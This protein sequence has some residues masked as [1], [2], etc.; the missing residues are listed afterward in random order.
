MKINIELHKALFNLILEIFI[1]ECSDVTMAPIIWESGIY[2]PYDGEHPDE[3]ERCPWTTMNMITKKYGIK[4]AR[5]ERVHTAHNMR[6]MAKS[7]LLNS[8]ERVQD[9]P[10]DAVF[11]YKVKPI[12]ESNYLRYPEFEIKILVAWKETSQ[13]WDKGENKIILRDSSAG[14]I[15]KLERDAIRCWVKNILAYN[16]GAIQMDLL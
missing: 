2:Q 8:I 10:K 4:H 11:V 14:A 3:T 5:V 13:S 1:E 16:I 6:I 15:P 12:A 7:G 9:P